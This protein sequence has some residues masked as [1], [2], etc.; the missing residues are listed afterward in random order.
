MGHPC[1]NP[2]RE[3]QDYTYRGKKRLEYNKL[4]FHRDLQF[5]ELPHLSPLSYREG[6]CHMAWT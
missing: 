3:D 4:Y 5:T 2:G 6:N 1:A